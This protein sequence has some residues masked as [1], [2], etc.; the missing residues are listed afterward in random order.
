MTTDD[1]RKS[2]SAFRTPAIVFGVFSIPW[3]YVAP[4]SAFSL[5]DPYVPWFADLARHYGVYSALAYPLFYG[6]AVASSYWAYSRRK[7][8]RLILGLGL[9]PLLSA[10]P[11]FAVFFVFIL[12]G[13][14]GQSV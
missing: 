13:V 7:N 10:Y 2:L 12:I 8:P 1:R 14:L 4:F 3:Y 5:D 11:W 6:V 9:I